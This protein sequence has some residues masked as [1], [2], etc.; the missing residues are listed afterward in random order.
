MRV[1]GGK[2]G[3]L[4]MEGWHRGSVAE[5][6]CCASSAAPQRVRLWRGRQVTVVLHHLLRRVLLWLEESRVKLWENETGELND[7]GEGKRVGENHGSDLLLR[8]CQVEWHQG[9]PVD[10]V[11]A[12][13]E[14]DEPRL[15]ESVRALPGLEGVEGG[16][17]DEEEGEEEAGHEATLL[18][19]RADEDP[20]RQQIDV[21]GL[22]WGDDQPHNIYAN[23]SLRQVR[24]ER[25]RQWQSQRQKQ[26]R[27]Q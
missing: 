19:S 26:I 21:Q 25:Q 4:E 2:L 14:E 23:L 13:G 10:R 3:G 5:A 22:G 8:A 1:N 6:P 16:K 20:L 7:G 18:N 15:V 24:G 9:E 12:V 11:D 17:D 27:R